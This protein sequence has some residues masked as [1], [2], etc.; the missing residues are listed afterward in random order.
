MYQV[1]TE[2]DLLVSAAI[3][4]SGECI[5]FGGSGGYV[6]LWA[7]SNDPSANQMRQVR[8]SASQQRFTA[9][10]LLCQ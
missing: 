9:G 8:G 7:P 4:G 2:G 5:A 1:E 6:H 3:S 10:W